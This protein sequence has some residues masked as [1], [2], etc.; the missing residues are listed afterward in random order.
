MLSSIGSIYVG[1]I[2]GNLIAFSGATPI[3]FIPLL[4]AYFSIPDWIPESITTESVLKAALAIP[5]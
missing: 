3:N 4:I 2:L 5:A 1:F